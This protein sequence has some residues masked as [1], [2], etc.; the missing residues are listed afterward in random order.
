MKE[1]PEEFDAMMRELG[2]TRPSQNI[3]EVSEEDLDEKVLK[4]CYLIELLPASESQTELS[5]MASDLYKKLKVYE[6]DTA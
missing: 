5:I 2:Y 6:E 4:L 1:R 3:E